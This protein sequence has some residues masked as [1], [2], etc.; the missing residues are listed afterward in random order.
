[1]ESDPKLTK[2]FILDVYHV[3][4]QQ[5]LLFSIHYIFFFSQ[6]VDL[7]E[8]QRSK[9]QSLELST[10]GED[11]IKG[12][13]GGAAIKVLHSVAT[14]FV[15]EKDIGQKKLKTNVVS[16]KKQPLTPNPQ[17]NVGQKVLQV[18]TNHAPKAKKKQ[19]SP[20]PE[21]PRKNLNYI[22]KRKKL[23]LTLEDLQPEADSDDENWTTKTTP[24]LSSTDDAV[25]PRILPRRGATKNTIKDYSSNSSSESE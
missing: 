10:R 22:R 23:S 20:E 2:D 25:P 14:S 6:D 11:S 7:E 16:E 12:N 13:G 21:W 19:S 9:T 17:S 8:L 18:K 4:M 24:K 3:N 15:Q 5:E 1:M